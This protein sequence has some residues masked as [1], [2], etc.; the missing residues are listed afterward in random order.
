MWY[1]V[2]SNK[3]INSFG[4]KIYESDFKYE[5]QKNDIIKLGRIKFVIKEINIADGIIETTEQ[6]FKPFRECEYFI[7]N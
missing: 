7:I 5:L 3:P 6:I 1:V 2:K 4:N